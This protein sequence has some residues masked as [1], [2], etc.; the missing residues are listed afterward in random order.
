M[1]GETK[2]DCVPLDLTVYRIRTPLERRIGSRLDTLS[3]TG[4]HI[5]ESQDSL[6]TSVFL[7][8]Q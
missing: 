3:Y 4:S 7:N 1:D 6:F 8:K 5:S 2:E